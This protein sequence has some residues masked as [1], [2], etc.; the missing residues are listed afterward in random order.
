[1]WKVFSMLGGVWEKDIRGGNEA[2]SCENGFI[3]EKTKKQIRESSPV[4][5]VPFFF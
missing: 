3:D 4:G 2:M 1:M 5:R